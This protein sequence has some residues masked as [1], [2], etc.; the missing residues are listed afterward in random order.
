MKIAQCFA[1]QPENPPI[2]GSR[3]MVPRTNSNV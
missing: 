3:F 2:Q 1:G